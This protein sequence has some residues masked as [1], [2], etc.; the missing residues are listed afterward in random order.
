M[1][2]STCSGLDL[3]HISYP[4]SN[5]EDIAKEIVN[6]LKMKDRPSRLL[7]FARGRYTRVQVT[8]PVEN[9]FVVLKVSYWDIHGVRHNFEYTNE[10]WQG[11]AAFVQGVLNKSSDVRTLYLGI[12]SNEPEND[13][14]TW[15]R[16]AQH[17]VAQWDVREKSSTL[18]TVESAIKALIAK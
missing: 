8:A 6:N 17:A 16:E 9:G 2:W 14:L 4:T 1:A 10:N 11:A 12:C 5:M 7:L 18:I 15:R 13:A 3:R